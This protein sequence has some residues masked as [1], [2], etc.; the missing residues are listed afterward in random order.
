MCDYLLNLNAET[1][2]ITSYHPE[3][4]AIKKSAIASH[5]GD[6]CAG[7]WIFPDIGA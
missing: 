7:R 6:E 3:N 2:V 1:C 5:S 4:R